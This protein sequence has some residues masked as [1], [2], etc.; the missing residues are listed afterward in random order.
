MNFSKSTLWFTF[1]K[2]L[3][4]VITLFVSAIIARGLGAETFGEFNY[5]LS[6][7]TLLS[8]IASFSL[9]LVS[10]SDFS[11]NEGKL[12]KLSNLFYL[13]LAT[14][15]IYVL[16]I[17]T[18]SFLFIDNGKVVILVLSITHGLGVI[19][20]F[21][22]YFLSE[23]KGKLISLVRISSFIF[24]NSIKVCV[25]L[26]VKSDVLL[27]LAMAQVVDV[28]V[29]YFVYIYINRGIFRESLDFEYLKTTITRAFPLIL[30]SMLI[31]LYNRIDQL[32]ISEYLGYE[33]LGNYS[34]SV[35]ISDAFNMGIIAVVTGFIPKIMK[36]KNEQDDRFYGKYIKLIKLT[37]LISLFGCI[38]VII[39]GEF[40]IALVFG[41]EYM[42]SY[43]SMVVLIL[44]IPFSTMAVA[45][46]HWLISDGLE[47]IRMK[48]SVISLII[49]LILNTLLI[50]FCGILGAAIATLISQM[51]SGL[52]GYLFD[53]RTKNIFYCNLYTL[54]P[55]S[56]F[57]SFT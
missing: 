57:R 42:N 14:S 33:A 53:R 12:N 27:Y 29:V 51:Y 50:P 34:V 48:R 56:K 32:M 49:N 31:V 47:M 36:H 52:F 46:S 41:G 45:S 8:F 40:F 21:E 15:I 3:R 18:I 37:N 17:L 1:E 23:A 19:S 13:R 20:I 39:F 10:V 5:Y 55:I 43:L 35:R 38:F 26:F 30:S 28:I 9:D 4:L 24:S 54:V 16:I 2:A 44:S 11:K 22:S 6:I 7:V 25:I